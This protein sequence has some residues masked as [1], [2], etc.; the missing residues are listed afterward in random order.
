MIG[1]FKELV[2]PYVDADETV[3]PEDLEK[4]M[5]LKAS[6]LKLYCK[7]DGIRMNVRVDDEGTSWAFLSKR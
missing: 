1:E 6:T 4:T 7:D 5:G 3:S 2:Y